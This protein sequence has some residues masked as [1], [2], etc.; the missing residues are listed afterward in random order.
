VNAAQETEILGDWVG[1]RNDGAE[2]KIARIIPVV[3]TAAND[4]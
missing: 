1:D 2:P 3:Q 4:D